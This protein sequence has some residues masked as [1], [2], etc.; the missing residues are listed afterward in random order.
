MGDGQRTR[1]AARSCAGV[2]AGGDE[3]SSAVALGN[4]PTTIEAPAQSSPKTVPGKKLLSGAC[5]VAFFVMAVVG[6]DLA[7]IAPSVNHETTKVRSIE[8]WLDQVRSVDRHRRCIEM[9]GIVHEGVERRRRSGPPHK[10]SE[11]R[12][13]GG[14]DL[15]ILTRFLMATVHVCAQMDGGMLI[16]A[17]IDMDVSGRLPARHGLYI[18]EARCSLQLIKDDGAPVTTEIAV[19]ELGT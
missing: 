19:V 2:T 14:V 5:A 18:D 17:S 7:L 13:S 6:V 4:L 15:Y 3:E 10:H 12:E 8:V 11:H 9:I 1:A 16:E